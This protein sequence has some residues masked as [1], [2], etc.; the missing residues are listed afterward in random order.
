MS[1]E[2]FKG[3]YRFIIFKCHI[4]VLW[5]IIRENVIMSFAVFVLGQDTVAWHDR[6]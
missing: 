5:L 4:C 3:K 6:K 1:K 2:S